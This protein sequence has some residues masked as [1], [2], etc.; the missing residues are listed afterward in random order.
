MSKPCS[1]F[2]EIELEG[3]HTSEWCRG[4]ERSAHCG[5]NL[6]GCSYPDF[7]NTPKH[8]WAEIRERQRAEDTA[9]EVMPYTK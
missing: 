7:H 1:C 2:S 9:A 4:S 8:R 5:G 6:C 3:G